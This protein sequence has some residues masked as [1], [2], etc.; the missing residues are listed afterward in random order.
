MSLSSQSGLKVHD[1]KY[2]TA[3]DYDGKDPVGVGRIHQDGEDP[4]TWLM[5]I[6]GDNLRKGA[7]LNGI[8]IAERIFDIPR[9]T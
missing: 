7:A 1:E 3:L 5:W 9:P 4:Q 2:P 6:V 8:Q